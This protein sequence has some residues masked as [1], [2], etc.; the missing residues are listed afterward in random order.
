MFYE[1]GDSK[2]LARIMD[3]VAMDPGRLDAYR[4]RL[5]AAR[6]RMSW[7]KEKREIRSD[8]V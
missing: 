5:P 2:E 7:S 8:A 3:E 4:T 1:P 6:E